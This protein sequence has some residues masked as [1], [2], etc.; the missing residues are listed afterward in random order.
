MRGDQPFGSRSHHAIGGKFFNGHI[1]ISTGHVINEGILSL[2]MCSCF[3]SKA[4]VGVLSF[5][6][7]LELVF[8]HGSSVKKM[9]TDQAVSV[10]G[11]V[12]L[13]LR[14][15][16]RGNVKAH[17][18]RRH[19]GCLWAALYQGNWCYFPARMLM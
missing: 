13:W 6:V 14:I 8:I 12:Y 4:I 5:G 9:P 2:R 16:S 10:F 15:F 1:N 11:V 7:N 18:R 19:P 17:A 3:T